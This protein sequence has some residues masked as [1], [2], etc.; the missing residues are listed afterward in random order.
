MAAAAPVVGSRP[1]AGSRRM[2]MLTESLAST[3]PLET[4]ARATAQTA[5]VTVFMSNLSPRG[6]RTPVVGIPKFLPLESPV[7]AREPPG[8]A[9]RVLSVIPA[10]EDIPSA[11]GITC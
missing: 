6:S 7:F 5:C 8:A 10:R 2:P 11:E 9:P 3:V 1:G 4:I